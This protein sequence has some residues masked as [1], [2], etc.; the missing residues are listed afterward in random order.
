MNALESAKSLYSNEGIDSVIIGAFNRF[1][2]FTHTAGSIRSRLIN[3]KSPEVFKRFTRLS[4]AHLHQRYPDRYSD[5]DPFKIVWTDPNK[6]GS[7]T[8]ST[9]KRAGTVRTGD[10]DTTA[11]PFENN[12]VYTALKQRFIQDLDWLDTA[13][14][15]EFVSEIS[16]ST[17]WGYETKEE[18][19][20]RCD[21][22]ESL[23]QNIEKN[24]FK[25]QQELL[26]NEDI[27]YTNTGVH[28]PHLNE[29]GVNIG[30]N[31]EF[32]WRVRG[33][34]RLSVAKLLGIEKVP[35]QIIT[36][37][38]QWQEY[39]NQFSTHGTVPDEIQNHPDM[40]DLK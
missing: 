29:I 2:F 18:F 27:P 22:I 14:F 28:H 5:A 9:P 15:D 35:V 32:I 10:W 31:G 4:Q 19:T 24:G 30:R 33:Q 25:T 26:D 12:T 23:Y 1:I 39:R 11:K 16:N 21:D 7:L 37:H 36:R 40:Y 20:D 38:K 34:H 17:A 3:K 13:L 6:I 8:N